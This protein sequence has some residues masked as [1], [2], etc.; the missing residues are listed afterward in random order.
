MNQAGN[1]VYLV[2]GGE[3]YYYDPNQAPIGEGAT[4]K[5]YLGYKYGSNTPYAIK[6]VRSEYISNRWVEELIRKEVRLHFNHPNIVNTVGLGEAYTEPGQLYIVSEYVDGVTVEA[7]INRYLTTLPMEERVRQVLDCGIRVLSALHYVHRSGFIHRDIKPNNIMIDREGCVKLM[8]FG[9][10]EFMWD[11]NA[12]KSLSGTP[13]YLAPEQVPKTFVRSIVDA[14]ADLYSLGV[15]MYQMLTG[16]S[17]YAAPTQNEILYLHMN[18]ELPR[19][20]QIPDKVYNILRKATKRQPSER[21]D[22]AADMQAALE[23]V[24][25][26]MDREHDTDS[27]LGIVLGIMGIV[28]LV[29]IAMMAM[30]Y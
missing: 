19:D 3:F 2:A 1:I 8:D 21:Y 26:D 14:R 15:T 12:P 23:K 11:D 20:P 27:V 25:E 17:P 30:Y 4:S 28:I 22:S 9:I 13:E 29:L 24:R 5:V 10:A 7:W 16:V 18:Q 6:R